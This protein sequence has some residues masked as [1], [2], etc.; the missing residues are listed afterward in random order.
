M[1]AQR[2]NGRVEGRRGGGRFGALLLTVGFRQVPVPQSK[3]LLLQLSNC[4][5]HLAVIYGT[6]IN[7]PQKVQHLPATRFTS[8]LHRFRQHER[9]HEPQ[10]RFW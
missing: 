7:L 2:R 3:P 5:V 8:Q 10:P 6:P 4:E 9:L 1:T